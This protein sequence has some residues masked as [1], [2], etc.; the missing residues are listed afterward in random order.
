MTTRRAFV[1][2]YGLDGTQT[3]VLA[4]FIDIWTDERLDEADELHII[5][6]GDHP[7]NALIIEDQELRFQ[8]KRYY[9]D[10]AETERRGSQITL[11]VKA[12]ALWY[13]L[14][15]STLLGTLGFDD[16]PIINGFSVIMLSG[17]S[18][19][20]MAS[21]WGLTYDGDI[22]ITQ[23]SREFT[24]ISVLRAMRDWAVTTGTFLK[25]DTEM[26]NVHVASRAGIER[27]IGFRYG[28]NVSGVK[29]IARAPSVTRLYAYGADGLTLEG[30]TGRQYIE[31]YSWYTNMGIPLAVA[32]EKYMKSRVWTDTSIVDQDTLYAGAQA[33]LAA[34][35]Q[36]QLSY[37]MTVA[38]LSEFLGVTERFQVGD[39][40]RVADNPLAV[41][42][43]VTLTRAVRYPLKPSR[44][45][46]ELSY[47]Q[48]TGPS[49]QT[50]AS[51]G[52][53]NK[54]WLLFGKNNTGTYILRND[55]TATVNRIGLRF[56]DGGE[57]TFHHQLR[58]TGVGTGS[59]SV[60][61]M[62]ADTNE[63]LCVPHTLTYADG[64]TYHLVLLDV[65]LQEITGDKDYR[66]R[67]KTTASGG[68]GGSKGIN[69]APGDSKFHIFAYGAVR[70]TTPWPNSQLFTYT[71][72]PQ[73][74]T[75]PDGIS[76]VRITAKG[77]PGAAGGFQ[78]V[79][80]AGGTVVAVFPV[81]AGTEWDVIVGGQGSGSTPSPT[82][83]YPNGGIGGDTG[84]SSGSGGGGSSD[85]RVLGGAISTAIIVAPGGGGAA[86]A[87]TGSRTNQG[88]AGGFNSGGP[89]INQTPSPTHFANGATQSAGGSGGNGGGSP[90][91][92]GQGGDGSGGGAF[93]F[94]GGG[95]GGGWYGGEGGSVDV[96]V[97]DLHSQVGGGGGSG[98]IDSSALEFET[99]DGSVTGDNG[100]VL[101]EWGVPQES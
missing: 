6:P 71:G 40:V 11:H 86:E 31:D 54:Q 73:Q 18:G 3:G 43:R 97:G 88:G 28:R 20:G 77:A 74:F 13:R 96:V 9:V 22:P 25:F 99:D 101:F 62:D 53:G 35:S 2:T 87:N 100:S 23:Y 41:D 24:D 58:F 57:A 10:S 42:V 48:P 85:V 21:H 39:T 12:F 72:S 4:D 59:L 27:G 7:H 84:S 61:A 37:Q 50:G 66:I 33:R 63:L 65:W 93:R 47:L 89:G 26:Q 46:V 5:L 69:V 15:E 52:G 94:G 55:A 67:V 44:N 32:R 83:A 14:T 56:R 29:R 81:V 38:D 76:E 8:S 79:G 34:G 78:S 19:D 30:I 95:G 90:G 64:V 80:G 36:G 70:Q 60:S 75:V 98:W 91:T 49:I 82:G 1:Y 17:D 92:F 68:P 16:Q 51:A 45:Q